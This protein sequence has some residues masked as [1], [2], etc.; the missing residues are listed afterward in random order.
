[1]NNLESRYFLAI[2]FIDLKPIAKL[3]FTINCQLDLEINCK[4]DLEIDRQLNLLQ[5]DCK[6]D[7]KI[8]CNCKIDSKHNNQID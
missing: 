8:D 1:M 2:L 5:I 7:L 4:L 3:N 6:L